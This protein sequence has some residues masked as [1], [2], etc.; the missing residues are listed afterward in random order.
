MTYALDPDDRLYMLV[1]PREPGGQFSIVRFDNDGA[2]RSATSIDAPGFRPIAFAV[3]A[4]GDF[5]I[6]GWQEDGKG[7]LPKPYTGVWSSR[8][9]FLAR[10]RVPLSNKAESRSVLV[11]AVELSMAETAQDGYIYLALPGSR[12]TVHAIS[13]A[14]QVS[15]TFT[16]IPPDQKAMLTGLKVGGGRLALAFEEPP[17]KGGTA[18]L[19][20]QILDT[21]TGEPMR[22]V[23]HQSY[24]IGT[25][26]ACYVPDVFTFISSESGQM[27]MVHA[28]AR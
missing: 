25:A 18:K 4:S 20:I 5:L 3:F 27:Q 7:K 1:S 11:D 28:A 23:F 17:P 16:A 15:R 6:T 12:T 13:P 19:T 8:G 14:G 2:Y 10:V 9:Q 22:T 26:L 24:E 21:L